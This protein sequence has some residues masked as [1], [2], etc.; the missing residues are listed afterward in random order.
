MVSGIGLQQEN[1]VK[2][3]RTLTLFE[4]LSCRTV[5]A[6][7]SHISRH[8]FR[9]FCMESHRHTK[10]WISTTVR[11]RDHTVAKTGRL[12][13][14]LFLVNCTN[15]PEGCFT[16]VHSSQFWQVAR[17]CSA[18]TNFAFL[19]PAT[20]ACSYYS[21]GPETPRADEMNLA[22]EASCGKKPRYGAR[23][24]ENNGYECG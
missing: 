1:S 22:N 24:G 15:V 14:E 21:P 7:R 3:E 16:L 17:S 18:N 8:R 12:C 5:C 4:R 10:S 23:K 9:S 20:L 11:N 13:A 19:D 6:C 2:S